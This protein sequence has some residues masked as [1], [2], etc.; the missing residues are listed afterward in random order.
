MTTSCVGIKKQNFLVNEEKIVLVFEIGNVS[1]Q[2][3]LF[4]E[5][6][7]DCVPVTEPRVMR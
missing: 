3:A 4:Y 7:V 6:Q 2:N 5:T 1:V